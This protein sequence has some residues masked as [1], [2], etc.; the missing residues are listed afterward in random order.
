[1]P[2][3]EASFLFGPQP[4]Q[5]PKPEPEDTKKKSGGFWGR[6]LFAPNTSK[7]RGGDG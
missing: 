4:S 2:Q 6:K 3:D 5:E 1:M 7:Y